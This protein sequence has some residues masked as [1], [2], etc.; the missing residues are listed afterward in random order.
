[1]ASDN[2]FIKNK[3][4]Y[5]YG[6]GKNNYGQLGLGDTTDRTTFTKIDIDN[7]KNIYYNGEHSFIIKNDG[8]LWGCGYNSYGQLGLGDTDKRTTFTKVTA[9]VDNIK[10]IFTLGHGSYILKEDF[11]LYSCGNDTGTKST[12]NSKK[13]FTYIT[14]DINNLYPLL[15][16]IL[17]LIKSEGKYYTINQNS[18]LVETSLDNFDSDS[19]DIDTINSNIDIL[20]NTFNL[21]SNDESAEISL[22]GLKQ[23]TFMIVSNE[24]L[25]IDSAVYIKKINSNKTLTNAEA[26]IIVSVDDGNTYYTY[27]DSKFSK[28]DVTIPSGNYSSFSNTDKENWENSKSKILLEG[29]DIND[30]NDIDFTSLGLVY[31]S[32]KLKYAIAI[33]VQDTSSVVNFKDVTMIYSK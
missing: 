20:P 6:I 14:S 23:K 8:T 1:M 16:S 10:D 5:I 3:D 26:K 11:K 25:S 31:G 4:G 12:S 22:N 19:I 28:I 9:N 27:K 15:V 24:S 13:S 29:I 17:L 33:S 7:V 2:L 32:M 30:L 21:V 18:E